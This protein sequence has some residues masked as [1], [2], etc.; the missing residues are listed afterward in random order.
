MLWCKYKDYVKIYPF[1]GYVFKPA[2]IEWYHEALHK[3]NVYIL[4]IKVAATYSLNFPHI[5]VV[6]WLNT[7]MHI[8]QY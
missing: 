2:L 5:K 8:S 6:I 1:Q 3:N 4:V 7:L